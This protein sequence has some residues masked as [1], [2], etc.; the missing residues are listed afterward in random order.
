MESTCSS[1]S[2]IF[3][4]NAIEQVINRDYKKLYGMVYR[5]TESHQDTED[6][7]QNAFLKVYK[8]I[9]KFMNKS[10]LSTWIYKIVINE[11]CRHMKSWK[12]LPVVAIAE[13]RGITEE[14]FF[15][16]LE[17]VP[18]F[19]ENLVI[20]ELREKCLHGFL[21]CIPKKMRVCFLLKTCLELKNK[22][23]AEVMNITTDNVKVTLYR[24]RKRLKEMF[25][26]RCSLID[27]SKPCKCYFWIKYMKD[28]NLPLPEGHRQI[29]ADALKEEHF[30]NLSLLKKIDY[31][32]HAEESIS[33]IEFINK[34]KKVIEIL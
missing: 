7:L 23:I 26:D 8:N 9:D 22:E 20:E 19:S 17:F 30:R 34:L 5:M 12:K 2:Q 14:A 27:P 6:I 16:S 15:N 21:R 33:K 31:L 25:E 1:E 18:D 13:D 32:Y 3:E 10:R 11:S 28:N 4:V 29:K 24:S